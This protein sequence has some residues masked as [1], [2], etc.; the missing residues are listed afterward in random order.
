[1]LRLTTSRVLT[2]KSMSQCQRPIST[3]TRILLSQ[4][5]AVSST[6]TPTVNDIIVKLTF[7]DP[8]GARRIV[9]G[10]VGKTIHETCLMHGIDIGPSSSG[11]PV[12][13]V[14]SDTW[15]ETLYGEG[16]NTGFDHVLISGN[17]SDTVKP[18]DWVEERLLKEYWDEDELFPESRLASQLT[19]NKAMDG[20]VVYVPDR[21]V[22]DCP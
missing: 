18:V 13:R 9:P 1:M 6:P 17:G 7:I 4:Q 2:R 8:T 14:N 16:P 11:G 5:P 15:T 10:Y 22:D 21:L 12:E 19:L 3:N 20:M